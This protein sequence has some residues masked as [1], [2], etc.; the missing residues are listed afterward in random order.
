M[1]W[2]IGAFVL[3]LYGA[4]TSYEAAEKQADLQEEQARIEEEQ[5]VIQK[6]AVVEAEAINVRNV[7][8]LEAETAEEARRLELQQFDIEATTRARIAASGTVGGSLEYSA[9]LLETENTRELDWLKSAG[10]R[11]A[12]IMTAEGKLTAR[13]G[14]AAA[15]LTSAN[16]KITGAGAGITRAKGTASLLKDSAKLYDRGRDEGWWGKKPT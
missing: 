8:A 10:K 16:A 7:T 1:W 14:V 6:Q 13:R 11:R 2:Q 4:Y 12:R 15:N 9:L 5:A 3:S